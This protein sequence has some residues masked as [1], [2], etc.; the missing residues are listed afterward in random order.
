M[1]STHNPLGIGSR[2]L[3]NGRGWAMGLGLVVALGMVACQSQKPTSGDVG[4]ATGQVQGSAADV[5]AP[6]PKA[7]EPP[8]KPLP[9]Y[10]ERAPKEPLVG[11]CGEL[12]GNARQGFEGFMRAV[13]LEKAPNEVPY[14]RF[15]DTS[16]LVDNGAALGPAWA[17]LFLEGK[18]PERQ[19]GIEGWLAQYRARLGGHLTAEA[20][21]AMLGSAVTMQRHSSSSVKFAVVVP[22]REGASNGASWRIMMTRRGLEWLVSEIEDAP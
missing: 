11:G 22:P 19:K 17:Q 14:S 4:T 2:P 18:L 9:A 7:Q 12:C 1:N 8:K 15:L 16:I 20:V 6:S 5:V 13:L 10:N 3:R 21:E